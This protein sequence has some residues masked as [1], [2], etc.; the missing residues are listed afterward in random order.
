MIEYK[1]S[2]RQKD[3]EHH[4]FDNIQYQKENAE[5]R[6]SILKTNKNIMTKEWAKG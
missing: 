2:S 1:R 6:Q 4:N 5:A 3:H